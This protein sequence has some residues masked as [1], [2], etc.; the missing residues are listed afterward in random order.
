M[1][2]KPGDSELTL[3]ELQTSIVRPGAG[4]GYMD[5]WH[6]NSTD[7]EARFHWASARYRFLF[8]LVIGCVVGLSPIGDMA[9][10][11]QI[12]PFLL[13]TPS[14]APDNTTFDQSADVFD[15]VH[16]TS[17]S[18]NAEEPR[19]RLVSW[20]HYDG[21]W[22]SIRLG[23]VLMG[24]V[25]G[26]AQDSGSVGQVGTLDTQTQ[27]RNF[28]LTLSGDLN[29]PQPW[30]YVVT[31]EYEGF[32]RG[33]DT[34]GSRVLELSELALTIP[35]PHIGRL[36]IG[37]FKA[38]ISLDRLTSSSNV[39]F[40]ERPALLDALL[41]SRNTGLMLSNTAID[42]HLTWSV[43]W[44]N[45]VFDGGG[46]AANTVAARIAGLPIDTEDT[47]LHLGIAGRWAQAPD[48]KLHY[49]AR[50]EV[51]QAP[52]F[53][54]TGSFAATDEHDLDLELAWQQGPVFTTAEYLADWVSSSANGNPFFDGF[55]IST[56]WMLTG[57]RRRY[58]R[59]A[60]YFGAVSPDH[61][62][63]S[64]GFGAFEVAARYTWTDLNDAMIHGGRLSRASLGINWYATDNLRLEFNYGYGRLA[65]SGADGTTNFF[66]ARLQFVF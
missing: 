42:K 57:E 1:D 18:A 6:L 46:T 7:Q 32:D 58:N 60:G 33:T 22:F 16:A 12:T 49:R 17:I 66:Q 35:L 59:T 9:R 5:I 39:T 28:R 63:S 21:E 34:S 54:D 52:H 37:K 50:P 45:S 48:G 65:R 36:A 47:L 30:S 62:L 2:M 43:G 44:F 31:G 25:V 23:G 41:P 27:V 61:P 19:R 26:Y 11:G 13:D 3:T 53:I 29:F 24:D 15:S 55:Y 4:A 10:A 8:P 51:N 40:L 20:N 64:G 38:P 14:T 56:A